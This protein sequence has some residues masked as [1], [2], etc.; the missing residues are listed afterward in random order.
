MGARD[1]QPVGLG[2]VWFGVSM[3]LSWGDIK[4]SIDYMRLEPQGRP[5]LTIQMRR[6]HD[7]LSC[8]TE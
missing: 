3:G 4:K 7:T 6:Q 5:V 8:D 2:N 1:K